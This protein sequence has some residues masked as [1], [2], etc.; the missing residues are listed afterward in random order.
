[1]VDMNCKIDWISLLHIKIRFT[2]WGILVLA[3]LIFALIKG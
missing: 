1:M 3:V 2:C